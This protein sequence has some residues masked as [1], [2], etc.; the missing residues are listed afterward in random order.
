MDCIREDPGGCSVG[1]QNLSTP[2][3][4]STPK[5]ESDPGWWLAG[6]PA[7]GIPP[8]ATLTFEIEVPLENARGAY[9]HVG[10]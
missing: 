6:F 9:L 4:L 2:A 1:L 8:G 5:V 10:L 7:W 3:N